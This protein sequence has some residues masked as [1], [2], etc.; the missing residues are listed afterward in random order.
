MWS[1]LQPNTSKGHPP[2]TDSATA[3]HAAPERTTRR[4]LLGAG[5]IG[6]ALALAGARPAAAGT[7]TGLSES[8]TELTA[9]AISLELTARDLYGAAIAAGADAGGVEIWATM[10][11]QH[12]AY[13]QRLAGISGIPATLRD[14]ATFQLL[15]DR[16][17][18]SD[19][20]AVAYELENILAATNNALTGLVEDVNLAMALA[21]F[22][23]IESRHA[24]VMAGLSGEDDFDL[25]YTNTATP[26]S[27]EG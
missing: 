18:T 15:V 10:R 22:V 4:A 2:V 11:D 8:D 21:S 14:D 25:L 23:S 7:T 27:P 16:F 5:V 13:A 26:L 6:A 12:A 9:F 3:D 24:V 20:A 1:A 17:Q 19:P